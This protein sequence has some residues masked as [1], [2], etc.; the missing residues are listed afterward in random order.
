MENVLEKRYK[1]FEPWWH[2]SFA[3]Q[4]EVADSWPEVG[5]CGPGVPGGVAELPHSAGSVLCNCGV[6]AGRAQVSGGGWVEGRTGLSVQT[7]SVARPSWPA[8]GP[9]A[10]AVPLH[11]SVR[12]PGASHRPRSRE[13]LGDPSHSG[14]LASGLPD[15]VFLSCEPE[16]I[17][18]LGSQTCGESGARLTSSHVGIL[19]IPI[20]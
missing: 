19:K 15:P 12:V 2:P 4:P 7:W 3:H 14:V 1:S 10:K 11:F 5:L 16:I 8:Q 13:N 9:R 17:T 6:R 18:V 20:L